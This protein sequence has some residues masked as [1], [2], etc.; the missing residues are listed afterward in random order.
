[1]LVS[2]TTPHGILAYSRIHCPQS[3]QT[4][5]YWSTSIFSCSLV[6]SSNTM[7]QARG[8][9]GKDR[10]TAGQMDRQTAYLSLRVVEVRWHCD[11][12]VLHLGS[13]VAFCNTHAP[14]CWCSWQSINHANVNWIFV[15]VWIRFPSFPLWF[16]PCPLTP[17]PLKNS[18]YLRSLSSS[19]VRRL[20]PGW[21]STSSHEP[22]PRHRRWK[23]AQSCKARSSCQWQEQKS[24]NKV[25]NSLLG[26]CSLQNNSTWSVQ[27]DLCCCDALTG[28]SGP[29]GHRSAVRSAS[30]WRT[31]CSQGWW[32]PVV[33]RACPP[34]ARRRWWRRWLRGWS[35][36]PQHSLAPGPAGENRVNVCCRC[37]GEKW[38]DFCF[39]TINERLNF[40][41]IFNMKKVLQKTCLI[42]QLLLSASFF[43]R[44]VLNLHITEHIIIICSC[45][46]KHLVLKTNW[47]NPFLFIICGVSK[48]FI[49]DWQCGK[50]V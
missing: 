46:I 43:S 30:W 22:P 40:F 27:R 1:M 10:W 21:V 37:S 47:R 49:F 24:L 36:R 38:L 3:H 28:L 13:Q 31:A 15:F 7:T 6:F 14:Q 20:R 32:R 41:A 19:L 11:H 42:Y 26:G 8:D 45:A 23:L 25:K 35:W 9:S 18:T 4:G 5:F 50:N 2:S 12:C 16:F 39:L 34:G 33:W 44:I 29:R 48:W 17:D